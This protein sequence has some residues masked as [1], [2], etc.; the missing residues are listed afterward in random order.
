[1]ATIYIKS[2]ND[3]EQKLPQLLSLRI[4]KALEM[5][6]DEIF[7]IFMNHITEYYNE[8][9]FR[10][11]ESAIPLLYDRTYKMLNS[12]IKTNVVKEG[13]NYSCTVEIDPEYL[14]Y[15]YF[16]GATG[17]DVMLSADQQFHGWSIEG[18]IKVWQDALQ[19]IGM[20]PGLLYIMMKNL[21]ICGVPI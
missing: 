12:L 16:G 3:L 6:R 14:N 21:K 11:G 15:K 2:L 20:E 19:D 8:A 7:P 18:D 1:M 13:N 17:L 4:S 5:T 9:V 10:N